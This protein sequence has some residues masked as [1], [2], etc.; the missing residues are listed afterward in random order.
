MKKLLSIF[1]IA[2]IVCVTFPGE[3]SAATSAT[4]NITVTVNFMEMQIVQHDQAWDGTT[5]TAWGI[6]SMATSST[7]TMAQTD[8]VKVVLGSTSQTL[9]IQSHVSDEGTAWT[10]AAAADANQY[11]IMA[12][13]YDATQASPSVAAGTQL[14]T[15][16]LDVIGATAV[17]SGAD[18]WLYYDFDSPTSVGTGTQQT[19]VITIAIVIA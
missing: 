18:R 5:Y 11:A 3:A 4:F 1:L 6:G 7:N 2:G 8:G 16:A 14:T 17:A 9:D 10:V 15:S 13:G 19:I 12:K